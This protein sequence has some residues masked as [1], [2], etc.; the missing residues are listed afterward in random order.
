MEWMNQNPEPTDPEHCAWCGEPDM[1]GAA[2]VPM[3]TVGHTWLHHRCWNAWY[4]KRRARAL[5][6]LPE[7]GIAIQDRRGSELPNDFGK[8]GAG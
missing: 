3:G 5:E 6:D 8:S 7:L 4:A 2:V 1:P